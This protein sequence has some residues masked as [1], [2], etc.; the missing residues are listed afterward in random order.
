MKARY[1]AGYGTN[2][3]RTEESIRTEELIKRQKNKSNLYV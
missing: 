1:S 3:Q 2:Q